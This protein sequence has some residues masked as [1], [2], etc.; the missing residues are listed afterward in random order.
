MNQL[1]KRGSFIVEEK[2]SEISS[3]FVLKTIIIDVIINKSSLSD[4]AKFEIEFFWVFFLFIQFN[5][6]RQQL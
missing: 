2:K 4:R 3:S 5:F 6:K 1:Q